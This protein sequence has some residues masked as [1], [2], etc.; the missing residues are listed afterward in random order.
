[1][2]SGK[3]LS[4]IYSTDANPLN[5]V[6]YHFYFNNGYIGNSSSGVFNVTVDADGV[7]TCVPINTVGTGVNA[8]VSVTDVGKSVIKSIHVFSM[9]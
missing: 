9:A 5:S 1:M 2:L 4:L 8:T 3:T 6:K 7:Y